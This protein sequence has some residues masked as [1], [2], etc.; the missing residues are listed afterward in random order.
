MN[1]NKILTFLVPI[2]SLFFEQF[3]KSSNNLVLGADLLLK[4]IS[5]GSFE[6]RLELAEQMHPIELKGDEITH[7]IFSE[8]SA[9]FIT[10]FDR[11]DIHE[12]A[13]SLDTILDTMDGICKRVKLYKLEEVS[14]EMIQLVKLVKSGVMEIQAA[15]DGLKDMKDPARVRE[16][17]GRID[18]IEKH[19]DNIHNESLA[20]LFSNEK[21]A[22][23][24]IKKKEILQNLE[25]AVD[26]CL[27][28]ANV[29]ESILIKN[30]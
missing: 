30:S 17:I 10:P 4:V 25:K 22:I 16:A 15:I 14:P 28:C 3:T 23:A 13:S 18:E 7:T 2:N 1:F 12:L 29:I 27:D 5:K 19:A 20:S 24:L 8:L 11:E 6:D 21:D 9:N 26:F